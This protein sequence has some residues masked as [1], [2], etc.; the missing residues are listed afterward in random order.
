MRKRVVIEGIL[1]AVATAVILAAYV[2]R[3]AAF[4]GAELKFYDLRSK[5]RQNL[6]A[7]EEVVLVAVDEKSIAQAGRWPWPRSRLAAMVEKLSASGAKVIGL[8][9]RLDREEPNAGLAEVRRLKG[10]YEELLKAKAL[11]DR[12][13]VFGLEFSSAIAQVDSDAKLE[14]AMRQAANVV[15]PVPF[16]HGALRG[17][18]AEDLAA[19]SSFTV[20]A[21]GAAL[22]ED[23]AAAL[24]I[25][26]FSL[27][28]AGIGHMLREP[29]FDG[30][31]R[32]ERPVC[33]W[34]ELYLPSYA[35]EL[36]LAYEGLKPSQAVYTPGVEVRAGAFRIP[37]DDTDRWLVTYNGPEQTI[38]TFSFEDVINGKTPPDAFKGKIVIVGLTAP[39]SV[40]P[41]ATPLGP[42]PPIEA[43]ASAVENILHHRFL[44]RPSWAGAVELALAVL[45]GLFAVFALPR[46]RLLPALVF[47]LALTA[48]LAAG[49]SVLFVNGH[50]VR[51]AYSVMLLALAYVLLIAHRLAEAAHGVD[52]KGP[53]KPG[54]GSYE[55]ERELG[56]GPRSTAYLGRDPR[57]GGR[58]I[59]EVWT[60][61]P[62]PD[63][64]ARKL[65]N[66]FLREATAARGL[67]HP[68]LVHVT[69]AG[70]RDGR[71]YAAVELVEGHDFS[72]HASKTGLLPLLQAVESA[73]LAAEAL[74]EAHARGVVHGDLK[75]AS[76]IRLK[77]GG[78]R[79]AGFGLAC[80][81]DPAAAAPYM[82]PEA[83][84]G[85][86]MDGR[87]DLYSLA[88]VLY[89]LLTGEP[90]FAGTGEISELLFRIANEPAPDPRVVRPDLPLGFT[91]ILAKALAKKPQ[92]RYARGAALAADLR[93]AARMA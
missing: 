13:N 28:A 85:K 15:L 10:L 20:A 30:V 32:R 22:P 46:L 12:K 74:D 89:Q 76:L 1:G 33:R 49:G 9:T 62:A 7:A 36:V 29:D 51:V 84:A 83:A 8:E 65:E 19:V 88:A 63:E 87:S 79:L 82:S 56:R 4:E 43:T 38:Q 77:D 91:P 5:L 58:A 64:E 73:A 44:T 68:S 18:P 47:A 53:R 86:P 40:A 71:A 92:D 24:P 54:F 26:R 23:R 57:S 35:L 52:A 67:K 70:E 90:P 14:T 45:C 31:I 78:L 27:A 2:L 37:L 80:L 72:R 55:I 25:A 66:R 11:R 3:L 60:Q 17:A 39:E 6:T 16:L 69:E 93:A 41:L 42:L 59:L 21:Q 34:G 50:W 48:A 61:P 81:S 75:P